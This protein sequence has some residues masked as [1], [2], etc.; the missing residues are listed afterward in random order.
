MDKRRL[1]LW[2]ASLTAQSK[3]RAEKAHELAALRS[4]ARRHWRRASALDAR[5]DTDLASEERSR[6]HLAH[7]AYESVVAEL[8]RMDAV[9]R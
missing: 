6:A 9:E 7:A 1:R 8:R 2:Q 4:E 3:A 5:G